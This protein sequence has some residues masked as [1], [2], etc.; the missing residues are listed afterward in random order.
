MMSELEKVVDFAQKLGSEFVDV[1][2][3]RRKVKQISVV[4]GGIRYFT[5]SGRSGV[6]V[7]VKLKG[8]WG[9]A[10]TNIPTSDS[11]KDATKRAFKSAKTSSVYS[12]GKIEIPEIPPI[13][14]SLKTK[15]KVSSEDID[16]EEKLKFVFALDRAQKETDSRIVS[17]T[18]NYAEISQKFEL[19][20]SL[21]CGLSFELLSQ[22]SVWLSKQVDEN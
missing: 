19:A 5:S 15:I 9:L 18:S 6:A 16:T 1:R 14:K 7:R 11:L 3:E 17:R 4:N 20:N 22:L 2:F 21:G 12:K 8:A 10:S 13:K